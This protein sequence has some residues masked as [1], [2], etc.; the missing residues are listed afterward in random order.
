[1]GHSFEEMHVMQLIKLYNKRARSSVGHSV[2]VQKY[3]NEHYLHF[4][5]NFL[6]FC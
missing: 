5:N 6:W 2:Y 4:F 3:N 1:M